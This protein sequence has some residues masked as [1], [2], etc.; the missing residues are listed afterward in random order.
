MSFRAT[1]SEPTQASVWLHSLNV[2]YVANPI[3]FFLNTQQ[4]GPPNISIKID[5]TREFVTDLV[6]DHE[7]DTD[8]DKVVV[9]FFGLLV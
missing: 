7:L 9:R 3:F 6:N 1:D 4:I 2:D 8:K 5:T